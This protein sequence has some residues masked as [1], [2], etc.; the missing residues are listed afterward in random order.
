MAKIVTVGKIGEFVRR[1]IKPQE[2]ATLKVQRYIDDNQSVLWQ[3]A[4]Y[5]LVILLASAGIDSVSASSGIDVKAEKMYMK[6]LSVGKW[7]IIGKGG[8]DTIK[9][10][11]Q[12]D[13][14]G[15]QKNFLQYL[16]IYA[17]LMALPWGMGEVEAMFA[18]GGL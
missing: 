1:E 4:G 11:S 5:A 17:L 7:V 8:I 6:L 16:L 3:G 15:A 9:A 10:V 2:S 13:M 12:N 14:Q 18:D